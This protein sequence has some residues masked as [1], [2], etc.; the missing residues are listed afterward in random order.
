MRWCLVLFV[1]GAMSCVRAVGGKTGES[2]WGVVAAVEK[3]SEGR[4]LVVFY[5][6]N[7]SDVVLR[8]GGPVSWVVFFRDRSQVD[9]GMI[10]AGYVDRCR[11]GERANFEIE[12]GEAVRF[13]APVDV[14]PE[15][16]SYEVR[17]EFAELNVD[18]TCSPV[19]KIVG[20]GVLE[21]GVGG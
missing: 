12:P 9:V 5:L 15:F 17:V 20:R 6:E 7:R 16:S 2:S 4:G 10:S 11:D 8:V 13:D 18:G 3:A 1:V 14:R 19:V 21:D